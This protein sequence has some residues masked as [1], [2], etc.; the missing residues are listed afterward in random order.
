M[1]EIRYTFTLALYCI[2]LPF[3]QH[4]TINIPRRL[5]HNLSKI[6][7]HHVK[8]PAFTLYGSPGSSNTNRIRLVL[9][10]GGF[11]DY[12]L[13]L[14]NLPKGEQRV[15]LFSRSLFVSLSHTD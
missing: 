13:V 4:M 3:L 8:M 6:N 7:H 15:R 14:L 11:T 5:L 10:E 9:A 12:D 2:V 1:L